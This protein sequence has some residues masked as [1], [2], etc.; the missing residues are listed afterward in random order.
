MNDIVERLRAYALDDHERGC[1]G[2]Y[3]DCSC[4][5]DGKRGPLMGEAAAEIERLRAALESAE[6]WLERW[7]VHVGRCEGGHSCTCGLTA[8]QYEGSAALAH[9]APQKEKGGQ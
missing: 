4:G 3:Y 8:A 7:A 2:R 6:A 9:P 5:Y 1:Q